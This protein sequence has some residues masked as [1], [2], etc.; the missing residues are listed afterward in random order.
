M[1]EEILAREDQKGAENDN[2]SSIG[3]NHPIKN[4][5]S[6]VTQE[7]KEGIRLEKVEAPAKDG[8][9]SC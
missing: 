9:C 3:N 4:H 8:D 2:E 6:H 1:S 7:Q 5:P